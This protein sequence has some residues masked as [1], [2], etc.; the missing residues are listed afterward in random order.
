MMMIAAPLSSW[1]AELLGGGSVDDDSFEG[2]EELLERG[3]GER[4]LGR[5]EGRDR[6]REGGVSESV[7]LHG[8]SAECEEMGDGVG[9]DAG[10]VVV[11]EEEEGEGSGQSA[12][13]AGELVVLEGELLECGGPGVGQVVVLEA[14]V[15]EVEDAEV[16]QEVGLHRA[17]SVGCVVE[18]V[19]AEQ[20]LAQGELGHG[21]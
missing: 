16:G 14:V 20:Q 15:G 6:E 3:W 11:V 2:G 1:G 10:D 5:C 7:V 8:E 18:A 9:G 13:E 12:G 17:K 19:V 21:G 4:A